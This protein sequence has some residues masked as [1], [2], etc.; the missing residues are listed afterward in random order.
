MREKLAARRRDDTVKLLSVVRR[1]RPALLMSTA[2]Q[3]TVILVLS[4]PAD[5]Q[6]APNARPTGGVVTAGALSISQTPTRTVIDQSSQRGAVNWQSYNVGSQQSVVYHQPASTSVTLNR[7]VGPD[8]S[9]IAGRIDAN[10]Q[11][12]LINQSGV[13]FYKGAQVNTAGLIVTTANATDTSFMDGHLKFDQASKNPNAAIDNAGNITIKDAGLTALVAPQVRNSGTITAQLGHIVLAGAK[14]ATLDLYGDGMLAL[15]VTD[16]VTQRPVGKDGKTVTALVTNTGVVIADGGTVQLTA[17]AADGIVQNL[18]EAGGR[19]R[20]ATMGDHTG[21]VALNGVG[22]SI[23]VAGQLSTPGNAPGTKGGAIEVVS[24]GNVTVASTTK[25]NASGKTGGGVVAIG[26]TLNRAKDAKV[27]SVLTAANVIVRAGATIVADAT[28][29]GYGGRVTVLSTKATAMAGN[30]TA[31][32]GPNGGDGGSVEVSGAGAFS[33]TGAIDVSAGSG[34][35]GAILL[36]PDNLE[37]I[38]RGGD[39][40]GAFFVNGGTL[41]FGDANTAKNQVSNRVIDDALKG[42]IILQANTAIA[43]DINTPIT[44][45]RDAGLILETKLGDISVGKDSPITASGSGFVT[46]HAGLTDRSGGKITLDSDIATDAATGVI[47]LQADGGIDLGTT[48]LTASVIDLSNITSGGIKQSAGGV[49]TATVLQSGAGVAGGTTLMSVAN[50][51][52]TIGTFQVT[53]GSFNLANSAAVSVLGTVSANNDVYLQTTNAGGITVAAG[54]KVTTGAAG[55]ASFQAA[56]LTINPGGTVTGGTFEFALD[57]PGALTL[58]AGGNLTSL[59]GI[60]TTAAEIGGIT[61]PGAGFT[62]TAT[63]IDTVATFDGNNLPV[64]LL[65]TGTIGE[66]AAA[67]IINVATLSG[68]ASSAKLDAANNILNLGSFTASAGDFLLSDGG[69]ASILTVSGPAI[70]T[71]VT[72]S[73]APTLVVTGSISASATADL[74]GGKIDLSTGAAVAGTTVALNAGAGGVTLTGNAAVGQGGGTV[75]INSTGAVSEAPT[76]II[77][78][79][80]LESTLGVADAV[81]LQGNANAIT[82]LGNFSLSGGSFALDDGVKLTVAGIVSA[83]GQVFL[84]DSAAGGIAVSGAVDPGAASLASFETDALAITGGSVT[85]ATFEL[86]PFTNNGTVVL[87]AGG[88]FASLAG[89]APTDVRIGAVTIPGSGLTTRV[90]SIAVGANFGTAATKLE[91]DSLG[92]ISETGGAITAAT[93]TG[94]AGA[95]VS[96]TNLNTIASLG[97]FTVTGPSSFTLNDSG[98]L[99]ITA[100]VAAATVDLSATAGIAET[101]GVINATTLLS[102]GGV[103]RN[104]LLGGLNNVAT[105]GNFLLRNGSFALNDG[106]DLLIAG[107]LNASRIAIR[108]PTNQIVLGDGATIITAGTPRPSGPL[109]TDLEPSNGGLGALLQSATF[110][111]I[112]GS[113]VLGQGGSGPATL[114]ISTTGF[115]LFDP[116]LGLQATGTW[117][118]LDLNSGFAAG[119][120]F[121][122]ALDVT[123][124]TP[125]GANLAGTLAGNVGGSAAAAGNI[126][127]AVNSAYLFNGCIIGAAVCTNG[128]ARQGLTATLGAIEPLVTL[129]P[130]NLAAIPELVLVALPML[131]GRPPQLTDPDVVPPNITYLDY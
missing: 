13:N 51:V 77:T 122:N 71:N 6:P 22:G 120:V 24:N 15:D 126:R 37:I 59:A 3:A 54:G 12:I 108:A 17:R 7:V 74:S 130:P 111:Q 72:I 43:V 58:G 88:T 85:G 69:V 93:L 56:K 121:V 119:N 8:P 86:A 29:K 66:A 82:N 90:G 20:A 41:A 97:S 48:K 129:P 45:N 109:Q 99:A 115:Q 11:I 16:R 9:Q 80:L 104:V 113:T 14:T 39:Q 55:R 27:T 53:G 103:T 73:G 63:S 83:P 117:L 116:P 76:S 35:T 36:D 46:F 32:G 101:T 61:I 10:G 102:S 70:G 34:T 60:A 44:L 96:L 124:T 94:Q 26:T 40:D 112:G 84:A 125:G 33:L 127:P 47:T 28:G 95:N 62:S 91:L 110:R 118:I 131:Q 57:T 31:R 67:P 114:Q 38:N 25:I 64:A 107:E 106:V 4:L 49:L 92:G 1:N 21:V 105:L 5:A 52:G 50:A 89:I 87:G 30:I 98:N 78:A 75:D 19:I 100:P 65:T 23:F 123:F 81:S 128:P 79:G 42:T 68:S 18:V 2:L